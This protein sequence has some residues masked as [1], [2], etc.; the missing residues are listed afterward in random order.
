MTPIEQ[1]ISAILDAELGPNP[2]HTRIAPSLAGL[3]A[4]CSAPAALP[5]PA[6]PFRVDSIPSDE[7]L[8]GLAR[9]TIET[10]IARGYVPI[11][12]PPGYKRCGFSLPA[13]PEPKAA[14]GSITQRYCPYT[15]LRE[16]V[17]PELVARRNGRQRRE[18]AAEGDE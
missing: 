12:H 14:D 15:L 13:S 8:H 17:V 1:A 18:S 7:Q 4:L 6:G 3:L 10:A 2:A 9:L 16:Y 11:Y 5:V